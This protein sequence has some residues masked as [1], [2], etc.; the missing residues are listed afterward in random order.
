MWQTH[1]RDF[2]YPVILT[3]GI[4]FMGAYFLPDVIL[5]NNSF[6]THSNPMR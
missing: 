3:I 4:I 5:N 6:N 1:V 2:T